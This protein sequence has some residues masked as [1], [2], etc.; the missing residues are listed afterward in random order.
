MTI[1]PCKG[2]GPNTDNLDKSLKDAVAAQL[3][4]GKELLNLVTAGAK[5]AY[6][7]LGGMSMPKFKSCCDIPAPCW[8]PKKLGDITCKLT[9]GETGQVKLIVTNNDVRPHECT[10]QIAGPNAGLVQISP[11]QIGLGPMQR[12]TIVAGFTAPDQPGTYEMLLWVSVCNDHFLRWTVV[13]GEKSGACCYDV[14]VDDRPDY[15]VH[16][17]DHFYCQKPCMGHLGK[18]P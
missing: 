5:S 13:V 15:V 12:T 7:G 1:T 11:A 2:D 8:M 17:Y 14:T 9:A 6:G 18:Y 3:A 10:V 4:L 16:W